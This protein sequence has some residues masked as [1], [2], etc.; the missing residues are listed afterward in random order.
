MSRPT[1]VPLDHRTNLRIPVG[2]ETV[3]ARQLSPA[4]RDDPLPALLVYTPYRVD[5]RAFGL[6]S[7]MGEFLAE[8]GYHVVFADLLGTGGSSGY[9]VEPLTGPEEGREAAG[10]VEWLADQ[11]WT[12]GKVG[13]FGLSYPGIASIAAAAERP[14]GLGAI[15]P[16]HAPY[17]GFLD[18]SIGGAF[19]LHLRG[20]HWPSM[21]QALQSLPPSRRDEEGRWARVWRDRLEGLREHEP[22]FFQFIEH[23]TKDEYWQGKDLAV[24]NITTPT[25][26]VAGYRDR[27]PPTTIDYFRQIDA[28]KRM[29]L[30]P[31]RHVMPPEGKVG[32]IDFYT[33]VLEWFDHFL[34][35]ENNGATDHEPIVY[36][37]ERHHEY[38]IDGRWRGTETWPELLW[39]PNGETSLE[40]IRFALTADGLQDPSEFQNATV[41]ALERRY[42][43]DQTV[44][45]SSVDRFVGQPLDTND[46]DAR[47]LTFET[48]P[49]ERPLELTGTGRATVRIRPTTTDPLLAVRM[50]D[51]TPDGTARMV[52]RG[53]LRLSHRDSLADPIPLVPGEDYTID[54]P[55]KPRSHLFQAGHRLRIAI[56]GALFPLML[57]PREHGP[58]TV[59][60]TPSAPSE[61]AF[62]GRHREKDEEFVD[63]VT[64]DPPLPGY[65]EPVRSGDWETSRSSGSDRATVRAFSAYTLP[66]DH[67]TFDYE[68]HTETTVMADDPTTVAADTRL[69]VA[70]EYETETVK[71]TVQTRVAHDMAQVSTNVFID[72]QP[73][74][75]EVWRWT[76]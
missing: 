61:I 30:G 7:P 68:E 49:L 51:V 15:V 22:W 54:L 39:V 56:S 62:P 37:T 64:M 12:T 47:S 38:G 26:A 65:A 70:L 57:P 42:E 75:D 36:W 74:F 11:D 10:I 43:T 2:S 50:L 48:A 24:G 20:G 72:E 17:T 4:D 31:W 13:M 44:G 3:S 53:Q 16:I 29:L 69:D 9:K 46:D 21:M 41:D 23:D 59:L 32:P 27:Y 33:Q 35:G 28:P 1:S 67:V 5:D 14:I 19:Q 40:P 73:V 71:T 25:L 58:F 66:F 63:L 34:K 52:T 6:H 60:S 8:R 55:L 45:M 18:N 76:R